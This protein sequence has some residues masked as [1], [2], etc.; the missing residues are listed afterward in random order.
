ME[1][2]NHPNSIFT[3]VYFVQAPENSGHLVLKSELFDR[4]LV[5]PITKE[6]EFNAATR[7][8]TPEPGLLVI[9]R[10]HIMHGALLHKPAEERISLSFTAMV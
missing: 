10:S 7:E 6:N 8:I 4:M 9:F 3:G 5:Y 2:H 1:L